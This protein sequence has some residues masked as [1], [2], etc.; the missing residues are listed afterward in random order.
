[1]NRESHG[2][3]QQWK[4]VSNALIPRKSLSPP[5]MHIEPRSVV[6]AIL[7]LH[8]DRPLVPLRKP[9]HKPLNLCLREAL[10]GHS[11]RAACLALNTHN[12]SNPTQQLAARH[13]LARSTNQGVQLDQPPLSQRQTQLPDVLPAPWEL[14]HPIAPEQRGRHREAGTPQSLVGSRL[15]RLSGGANKPCRLAGD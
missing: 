13:D 15:S 8:L 11:L 3:R 1:M 5:R 2:S 7:H 12:D 9:L 6:V 10:V 4:V 14:E